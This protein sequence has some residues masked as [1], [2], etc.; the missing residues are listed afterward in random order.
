MKHIIKL[1]LSII[2][3]LLWWSCTDGPVEVELQADVIDYSAGA[4]FVDLS[5]KTG[6]I[7]SYAYICYTVD[8]A[9]A[10]LPSASMV[11]RLAQSTSSSII[12]GTGSCSDGLNTIT[13]S[14]LD[15]ETY[16]VAYIAFTTTSEEFYQDVLDVVFLTSTFTETLTI[17][18][19]KQTG[20][21]VHVKFPDDVTVRGNA[22]RPTYA[23][24]YT[25]N[26][27]KY[28]YQEPDFYHLTWNCDQW[29]TS[30]FS[31]TYD[32]DTIYD[33]DGD[34][35][36]NNITAGEPGYFFIGEFEYGY[37]SGN[38]GY[39]LPL[40]DT[41]SLWEVVDNQGLETL[42]T[43]STYSSYDESEYWTGYYE[44]VFVQ[45]NP[46]TLLSDFSFNFNIY[47]IGA[48]SGI[49]EINPEGDFYCYL[50]LAMS[51]ATYRELL[52]Y[53][54]ENEDY[55][56]WYTTSLIGFYTFGIT[57]I[58]Q[59]GQVYVAL[60]GL[61]DLEPEVQ[62]HLFAVAIGDEEGLSQYYEHITFN[63]TERV[64]SAPNIVVTSLEDQNTAY[65][66]F[67]NIKS[68]Q[69]L[70]SAYFLSN[71]EREWNSYLNEYS[72]SYA[73]VFAGLTANSFH[74]TQLSA[75]YSDSGLTLSFP[76]RANST[77]RL[78]ILAYNTE[79]TP[80]AI[81]AS[82]SQAVADG[83]T[84]KET[85]NRI[86]SD[87]FEA[88][89]G[90]WS[91]SFT[92]LDSSSNELQYSGSSVTISQE[93]SIPSS[94]TSDDY[95]LYSDA[96]YSAAETDE[97]YAQL[98]SAIDDFNESVSGNNRLLVTKFCPT[99]SEYASPYDLFTSTSYNAA[100]PWG[101]VYDFG[102]KWYIEIAS[103]GSLSVPINSERLYPFSSWEISYGVYKTYYMIA[104]DITSS[105]SLSGYYTMDEDTYENLY[106][107]VELSADQN[108][109][110][111]NPMTIDGTDYYLN[112]ARYTSASLVIKYG[113]IISP[114]VLTREGASVTE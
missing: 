96:G 86:S 90:E 51:D 69:E 88:L 100:S 99:T 79:N 1:S 110:T 3:A 29:Y 77:T 12:S 34:M 43:G 98:Q 50:L 53:L 58:S 87:L 10:S 61:T 18:N 82:N 67:F 9:L 54:D 37:E 39:Y 40:C 107:P 49:L 105:S 14:D 46:P 21:S 94:L 17:Y 28:N 41:E 103:D 2:C 6:Q 52:H 65:E 74:S 92:Y 22:L 63:T 70:S 85:Y 11:Y 114:I 38:Y 31:F 33:S 16:Y 30:D 32:D 42:R 109:I 48:T 101:I 111:I 59:E 104:R 55:M 45:M 25:Y 91:I 106:F 24:I 78:A 112:I 95:A 23:D 35:I 20:F 75:M 76:S 7:A 60:E 108:Q 26:N 36:H 81:D 83:V 64:L 102:P 56:Q 47:E 113:T 93:I 66:V 72:G 13:I 5:V 80:N 62:Y 44:K 19:V 15:V 89:E 57:T 68:D 73:A 4:N 97:L 71:Y 27:A 8:N 84:P